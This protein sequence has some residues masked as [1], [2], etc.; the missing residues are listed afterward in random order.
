MEGQEFGHAS[1]RRKLNDPVTPKYFTIV[2]NA[3]LNAE[4]FIWYWIDGQADQ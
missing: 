4:G 2:A 1:Q 3:R